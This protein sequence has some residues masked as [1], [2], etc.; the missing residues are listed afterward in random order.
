MLEKVV[1][2][3]RGEIA[4]RI[5]RACKELGIKTVAIYSSIDKNLK[6]VLLADEKICIGA[7]KPIESYLNFSAIISAA[8]ISNANAIHPGYGFLSENA[9][10]AK[11]VEKS[12]LIFIGPKSET[13]RLMGDKISAI[14]AMKKIGLTCIPGSEGPL[15]YDMKEN[16]I[17][18]KKIG[19]PVIIK[20]SGGG[21]GR[22]MR[23]AYTEKE[24]DNCIN[25]T[26]AE[27]KLVFGTD[28]VYME[29]Y[30]ENPLHIEIQI[31]SDGKGNTIFL[32]ERDCSIQRRHQKLIEEAPSIHLTN[33]IREKI[34][35][36]C[37]KACNSI[38]YKGVGTFEFLYEDKNFYFMEM[39][40]RIQ[41][42]HPVTEMITGIDIVKE[43]LKI[44][45]K[46]SFSI[47]Q[48]DIK[49][50][51]H[52][53]ECRI[54]AENSKNCLPS[55]GKITFFHPPSGF[56]IRW[57]SHIY[58]GYTIPPYY[59]SMIGK[60]ICFAENRNIAIIKMKNALSELIIDGIHTNII[61]HTQILSDK[62]FQKMNTNIHFLDR[63]LKNRLN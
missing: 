39:N 4:L 42:E 20:S 38:R 22:G 48:E 10:F 56:G 63:F 1:I 49:I 12:G 6:H 7:N 28:I 21:G 59:D 62:N 14:K 3:N 43:Q 35:S 60:L 46:N 61:L 16:Y 30:L 24:L 51:G 9:S 15:S 40:T 53:I 25:I 37:I 45:S 44:A 13:I 57:E 54:N 34:S 33:E 5:L 29:K 19:Y 32:G 55:P 17:L 2:A 11:Q 27:S 36:I 52:A 41:V 50:N 31:L 47:K 8:K 26:R 18:G 23:I 58:N